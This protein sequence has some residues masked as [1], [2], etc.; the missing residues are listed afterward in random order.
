MRQNGPSCRDQQS[1]E[2]RAGGI[3]RDQ[4]RPCYP[5]A[6]RNVA[7]NADFAAMRR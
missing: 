3:G 6:R 1:G 2:C 4:P 7:A 5:A